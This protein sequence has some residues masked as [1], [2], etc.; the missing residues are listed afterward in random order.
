MQWLEIAIETVVL[1]AISS[2]RL[3]HYNKKDANS[4][5]QNN[6]LH[7]MKLIPNNDVI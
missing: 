6:I 7:N 1:I 2:L 5:V 4:V 3:L